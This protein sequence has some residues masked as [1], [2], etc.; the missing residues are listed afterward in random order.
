MTYIVAVAAI[1]ALAS[2]TGIRAQS[3]APPNEKAAPNPAQAEKAEPPLPA[4]P[5]PPDEPPPEDGGPA[6]FHHSTD[7]AIEIFR[8]RA[9]KNP[10]DYLSFR[11][12]GELYERKARETGSDTFFSDAESAL[13]RSLALF[14]TDPRA[15]ASL[16]A[17]LCARHR[18]AESLE[19]SSKLVAERPKD[20]DAL[21]TKGDALLELGRYGEAAKAYETLHALAPLPPILARLANLAEF[22]GRTGDAIRLIGQAALAEQS[23][24]GPK[25]AAW[26]H[27]RA[28]DIAFEAG[29][30][31]LAE[32]SY[33]AVPEG[34]DA[35]HDA[36]A[37]LARIRAAQGRNDE[38]IALF[39][40]AI[41]LGPDASMLAA[42]GDLHTHLGQPELSKPLFAQVVKQLEGRSEHRRELAMF[43][44]DHDIE[45]PRALQLARGDF[46]E[47]QD[48]FAY[49]TLAWTLSKNGRHEE[50]ATAARHA[51]EQGTRHARL[52]F[53]A[54]MIHHRL[55]DHVRAREYLTEALR[56]NPYFSIQ[57][58]AKAREILSARER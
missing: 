29:K 52:Y 12:L 7:E 49:D 2:P 31:D 14:E 21:A 54:G 20:L 13:R 40:K 50:A 11:Y 56:I 24:Y 30:L 6:A 44:A 19:I 27:A 42:L 1:A 32:S 55:G 36:T 15:R 18:F 58:A 53:H 22:Q 45:L 51:L 4:K 39:Q 47:R 38:A 26:Y 5:P 23:N 33:Q 48:V 41:A 35:F 43:Y 9:S 10:N 3:Q 8:D 28:G 57:D 17:V 25:G 34:V 37:G 16:A 46:A